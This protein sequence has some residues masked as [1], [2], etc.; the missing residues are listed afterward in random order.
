MLPEGEFLPAVSI[1]LPDSNRGLHRAEPS[2]E[3]IQEL[4]LEIS[5]GITGASGALYA[6]RFLNHL[7]RQK[8]IEKINLVA[9]APGLRVLREELHLEDLNLRNLA[10]R[11]VPM[12]PQRVAVMNNNDIGAP[13]ASGSCPVDAMV[14]LPCTMGTLGSIAH[15]IARDLIQRAA[16]VML[17]ERKKLI[18]VVRDTPLNLVQLDNMR[19]VTQA[20]GII[21]PATPGLY[22][23]PES[24]EEAI[25][26]F[27]FRVMLH[28][29]LQPPGL[30]RWQGSAGAI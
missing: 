8:E 11:L 5:V 16:D 17:K 13:I 7:S 29:G 14:I 27:L 18:L 1:Y 25:D 12:A 15:G 6:Q 10:E 19:K 22:P 23:G 21:F 28:L 9:S 3:A 20:G 26:Q 2:G 4:P 30:Y 24:L